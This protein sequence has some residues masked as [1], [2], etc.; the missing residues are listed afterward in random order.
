[1]KYIA[2]YKS[3]LLLLLCIGV[4]GFIGIIFPESSVITYPVGS[5]YL[6][7]LYVLVTPLIFFSVITAI[8][9]TKTVEK[10][11]HI[12]FLSIVTFLLFSLA[13]SLIALLLGIS[14]PSM[15]AC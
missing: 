13:A 11:K 2:N 4:G 6:N 10:A 9:S 1:M 5:I 8:I 14:L 15:V 3:S 12:L 7:F